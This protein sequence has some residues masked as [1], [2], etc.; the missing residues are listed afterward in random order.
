MHQ[1]FAVL[2]VL[3][4]TDVARADVCRVATYVCLAAKYVRASNA[5]ASLSLVVVLGAKIRASDVTGGT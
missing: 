3:R 4:R 5:Y 2:F 1:R